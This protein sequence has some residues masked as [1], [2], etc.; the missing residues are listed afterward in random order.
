MRLRQ[1]QFTRARQWNKHRTDAQTP[2]GSK[3]RG[4]MSHS[5]KDRGSRHKHPLWVHAL[6]QHGE[7]TGQCP[8]VHMEGER[9][10]CQE[11]DWNASDLEER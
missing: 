7:P 3:L 11:V 4:L 8:P 1:E 6:R 9:Q 5:G 2:C 10:T